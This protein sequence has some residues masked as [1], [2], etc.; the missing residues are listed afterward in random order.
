MRTRGWVS[1]AGAAAIIAATVGGGSSGAAGLP[2]PKFAT[3]IDIGLVSGTVVVHEAGHPALRLSTRDRA[4]PVGTEI[5]TRN[6]EVDLRAAPGPTTPYGAVQDAQ[7]SGGLFVI[8]QNRNQHGLAV[9]DLV[10]AVNVTATC[11][12]Y[13]G[14]SAAKLN[15]K[16]LDLLHSHDAHGNFQTRGRYSAATVRGTVW[17]TVDRCDG[18]LTVVHHGTVLVDDF[19]LHKTV[20]VHAGHRYL[21][22]AT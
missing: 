1:A 19:R 6:G 13:A 5:D 21:A 8:K 22:R 4:I 17:D 3:S 15:P 18:T 11:G 20:A 10:P 12:P 16:V 2:P 7:F 9:I 14:A